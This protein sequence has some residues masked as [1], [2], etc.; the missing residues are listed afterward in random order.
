[1]V[2]HYQP[3]CLVNSRIGNGLGTTPLWGDNQIPAAKRTGGLFETAGTLN[4][5]W[6]YKSFDQHWKTPEQ[7]ITLLGRLASHNVNY[8]LNVGPDHLGRIPADAQRILRKVGEWME[9][10]GEAIYGAAPSPFAADFPQGPVTISGTSQPEKN[11]I[12][13]FTIHRQSKEIFLPSTASAV[14]WSGPVCWAAVSRWS[15]ASIRPLRRK[16]P[17]LGSKN[18]AVGEALTTAVTLPELARTVCRW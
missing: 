4:D 3:N 2:K 5:T 11:S 17:P 10:N 13:C 1:M 9:T 15:C 7:T 16:T 18:P 14:A 6:G 8:L 12:S